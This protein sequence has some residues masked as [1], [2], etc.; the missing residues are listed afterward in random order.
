MYHPHD[1]A[2]SMTSLVYPCRA[3]AST[4]IFIHHLLPQLRRFSE[5]LKHSPWLSRVVASLGGAVLS[6]DVLLSLALEASW[7][8]DIFVAMLV[9]VY[10]ARVAELASR[11]TDA[12]MP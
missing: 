7:T 5:S 8:I 4:H 6:F 2:R 10:A 12:F 3:T 9:A 11:L 1:H